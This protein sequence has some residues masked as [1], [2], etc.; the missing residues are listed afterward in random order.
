MENK[1][2]RMVIE[3]EL[4]ENAIQEKGMTTGELLEA[5]EIHDHDTIDGFEIYP[6][7]EDSD[8]CSDFFLCDPKIV[9]KEILDPVADIEDGVDAVFLPGKIHG[10]EDELY[11]IYYNASANDEKGCFEI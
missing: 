8:L 1:K 2:V 9:S 4:D 3:F 7:L 5:I 11:I 10:C 6:A